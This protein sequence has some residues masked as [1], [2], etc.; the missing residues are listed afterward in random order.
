MKTKR[1]LLI[2]TAIIALIF[3]VLMIIN[4]I[5]YNTGKDEII[6]TNHMININ[7]GPQIWGRSKWTYRFYVEEEASQRILVSSSLLGR[8]TEITIS[9]KDGN[10]IF[11][12]SVGRENREFSDLTL[13]KGYYTLTISYKKG[14]LNHLLFSFEGDEATF[15]QQLSENYEIIP[16]NPEKGFNWKYIIYT[17]DNPSDNPHILVETNNTGRPSDDMAVHLNKAI[18]DISWKSS[19]ADKLGSPF[20]MPVFPRYPD[21]YD[22]SHSFDRKTLYTDHQDIQRLDL[23][24][25][26]IFED[27]RERLSAKDIETA[28]TM[29]IAGFSSSASF[30]S[31]FTILHPDRVRAMAAGAPGGWPIVPVKEYD[32]KKLRFPIGLYG[33]EDFLGREIDLNELRNTPLFFFMG[34]EDQ[35]DSVVYRDSFD[36]E[37]EELIFERFGKTPVERWPAAREIYENAGMNAKF[38]LYPDIGH[39]F[40]GE[41]KEDVL[42]FLKTHQ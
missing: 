34:A 38:K 11:S 35:N 5:H 32:G 23:Q 40:S 18:N 16:E 30:A 27:A 14:P 37:D 33:L 17:P 31:R 22:Y 21:D 12:E 3:I 20:I 13:K 1:A 4:L 41:M 26:A 25:L 28:D 24:L 42:N 29:L 36:K 7:R 39:S 19:F 9:E 8:Q 10:E 2:A 15:S 6:N